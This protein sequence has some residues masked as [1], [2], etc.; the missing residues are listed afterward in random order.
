MLKLRNIA[1]TEQPVFGP[2]FL[3]KPDDWKTKAHTKKG[4]VANLDTVGIEGIRYVVGEVVEVEENELVFKD[5]RRLLFG[6]LIIAAGFHQPAIMARNGETFAER[7]EF[8][9]AFPAKLK[10]AKS[11]LIGG[12]GPVAIEVAGTLRAANASCKI[13][14]VTSGERALASWNGKPAAVL[15]AR[16]KK[17]NVDV[18]TRTRVEVPD[19]VQVGSGVYEKR[20][21]NLSNGNTIK[22]VDIF[23]PFFSIARTSFLPENLIDATKRGRVKV[24]SMSQSTIRKNIFA[25]GCG[26]RWSVSI[27]P[28][29]QKEAA[30]V[31]QNVQDILEGK[32]PSMHLPEDCPATVDYVH[33]GLGEYT[34]MN[35]DQK[36][37][38]PMLGS[39]MCGCCFPLCPCCV[40]CGWCCSYPGSEISGK[41]F[42]KMLTSTG[43]MHPIHASKPPSMLQMER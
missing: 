40:C 42:G 17:I 43:N 36:G 19:D 6:A 4:F 28:S 23:L 15:A 33:V 31:A 24:N 12:A 32:T 11:V 10:S 34:M 29:I 27:V 21:Y 26:N 13:Q 30:A 5:G 20:D 22:N 8:L 41:C 16:L 18:I 1:F 2:L 9:Q 3:T 37:C 25:V 35:M 39:R 38:V 7:Q 14:L